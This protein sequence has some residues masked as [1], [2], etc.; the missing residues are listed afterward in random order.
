MCKKLL[1]TFYV[2][3]ESAML[4]STTGRNAKKSKNQYECTY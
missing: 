4:G 1:T 3:V 2:N